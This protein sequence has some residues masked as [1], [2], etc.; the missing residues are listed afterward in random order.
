MSRFVTCFFALVALALAALASSAAVSASGEIGLPGM[1]PDS[2]QPVL[3]TTVTADHD[4]NGN[5]W[6]C[7]KFQ[8]GRTSGGPDDKTVD[9]TIV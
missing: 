4:K 9:D 7:R 3:V 6:V 5:G 2:F 8:N 1:C